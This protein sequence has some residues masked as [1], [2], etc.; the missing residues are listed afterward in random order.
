MILPATGLVFGVAGECEQVLALA[1]IQPER[2]RNRRQ[3]TGR[4]PGLAAL[5]QPRVPGHADTGE[6]CDLLTA[7]AG[8]AP[9]G[10][11]RE[12]GLLGADP[13][14]SAAQ[15]RGELGPP[16]PPVG[17]GCHGA[18]MPILPVPAGG[19]QVVLIPG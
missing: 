10:A 18:H 14:A 15:E 5:L 7:Q 16:M 11:G 3:H 1:G 6:L 9:P 4:G 8:G 12:P 19:C 2:I 13:L 17:R